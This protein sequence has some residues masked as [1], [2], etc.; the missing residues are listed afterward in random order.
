M[1]FHVPV[2][3]GEVV[4]N[5]VGD[6]GGIY[7]DATAG[8]GGHSS[9]IARSLDPEGRLIAVDRDAE[10]VEEAGRALAE[11][12]GQV[13]VVHGRF[14]EIGPLL[15]ER[16]V[17]GLC[18]ALFDLG[19][20]SHQLEEPQRGFSY[21]TE[22]PLD[23]RMDSSQGLAAANLIGDASEPELAGPRVV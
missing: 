10:A 8:G 15:T 1:V 6:R 20:S 18:G 7:L 23:M 2:M 3:V 13:Q 4:D 19:V 21:Q 16:G 11:F 17:P 12:G 5:L 22:G 14:A 9:A